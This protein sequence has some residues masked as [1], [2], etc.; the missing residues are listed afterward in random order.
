MDAPAERPIRAAVDSGHLLQDGN[1]RSRTDAWSFPS[2][3]FSLTFLLP[4]RWENWDTPGAAVPP[5]IPSPL[6]SLLPSPSLPKSLSASLWAEHFVCKVLSDATL[7]GAVNQR[8][9]AS[10]SLGR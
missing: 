9:G 3:A 10:P 1:C 5:S 4:L 7:R 6:T 2:F 8:A